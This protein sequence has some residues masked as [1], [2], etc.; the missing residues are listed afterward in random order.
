MGRRVTLL[1]EAYNTQYSAAV[2]ISLEG[3]V[4]LPCANGNCDTQHPYNEGVTSSVLALYVVG[5]GYWPT[6]TRPMMSC[7]AWA[8]VPGG[9]LTA[10]DVGLLSHVSWCLGLGAFSLAGQ[11][12]SFCGLITLRLSFLGRLPY[13]AYDTW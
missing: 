10:V 6:D 11:P 13:W 5:G 4:S 8:Q 7:R 12:A 1:G 2:S 3:P 9:Y